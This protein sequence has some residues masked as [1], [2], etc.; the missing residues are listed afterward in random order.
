VA[1]DGEA[2]EALSGLYAANCDYD[3]LVEVLERRTLSAADGAERVALAL[4]RARLY[5]ELLGR[6]EQAIEA[7]KRLVHDIDPRCLAAHERL[8]RLSAAQ[9]DWVRVVSAITWQIRLTDEPPGKSRLGCEMA[10]VFRDRIGDAERARRAYE[11]ALEHDPDNREAL[12]ELACLCAEEPERPRLLQ[13]WERLLAGAPDGERR[14]RLMLGVAD[15]LARRL[16]DP[17][18]AFA[19]YAR[20][21]EEHP[22]PEALARLEA[23]ARAHGLWQELVGFLNRLRARA[24]D[25]AVEVALAHKLA[26]LLE[27]ELHDPAGALDGLL[28][29]FSL[30]PDREDTCLEVLRLAALTG[31]WDAALEAEAELF[32]R[33]ATA[34][35]KVEAAC[36]T[37]AIFEDRLRD[38]PSAFRHYLKAFRLAPNDQTVV[39]HLW[40]LAPT[41]Q[42][43]PSGVALSDDPGADP[44]DSAFA[45][46]ARAYELLPI[47]D[48]GTRHRHLCRAAEVW[49]SGVGDVSRAL[50]TLERAFLLAPEDPGVRRELR[51][52]GQREDLADQIAG[53]LSRSADSLNGRLGL[54]VR[55]DLAVFLQERGRPAEAE[56]QYRR[57][58]ALV[59]HDQ[60]TLAAIEQLTRQGERWPDLARILAKRITA[61]ARTLAPAVLLAKGRELAA[62]HEGRLANPGAAITTL[63]RCLALA[64][65]VD[66]PAT[67]DHLAEARAALESLARL[68]AQTGQWSRAVETIQRATLAYERR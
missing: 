36:R 16:G 17:R 32:A 50:A 34:D 1:D 6:P 28:E 7:L 20:A 19:W 27:E 35:E 30:A 39:A 49:E 58:L 65:P 38:L 57:L 40:R 29:A 8:R 24:R 46:L 66:K 60:G 53:I 44:T 18:S 3:L 42:A 59:P 21:C 51:R 68:Y 63:E 14:R 23:T 9:G 55:R 67:E 15:V 13:T 54:V 11:T 31:R 64:A 37:A 26:R 52:L 4:E 61:G 56:Q 43:D 22:D 25:A 2:L 12:E 10:A 62:L 5:E 47:A 48:T 45:A 41:I 33:A